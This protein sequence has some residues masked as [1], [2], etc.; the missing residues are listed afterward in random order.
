MS[1]HAGDYEDLLRGALHSAVDSIEP[2]TDGLDRIRAR[3]VA[4][5][6]LP[7]AWLTAAG[8]AVSRRAAGGLHSAL[9]RLR[10]AA[11]P[12]GRDDGAARPASPPG[13]RL[14]WAR[15]AVA[16]AAVTVIMAMSMSVLTPLGRQMLSQ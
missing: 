16:V 4:P 8:S 14:A 3:L 15:V 13:R 1:Q 9:A 5:Y 6:P 7:I 11:A 10:P 2:S 12:G